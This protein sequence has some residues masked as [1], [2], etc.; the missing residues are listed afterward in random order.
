MSDYCCAGLLSAPR[1]DSTQPDAAVHRFSPSPATQ[2]KRSKSASLDLF[3]S[4]NS[5]K[6]LNCFYAG[7]GEG[8]QNGATT[9]LPI[10]AFQ[11]C[12]YCSQLKRDPAT[13]VHATAT[14]S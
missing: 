14:W 8:F 11:V 1:M 4:H 9:S 7:K 6:F 12:T 3:S 2:S 5:E 10:H 13:T